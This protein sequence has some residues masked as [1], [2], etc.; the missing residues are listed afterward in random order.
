MSE[1]LKRTL[2]RALASARKSAGMTMTDIVN[3]RIF[4]SRQKLWRLETGQGPF[5][6]AEVQALAD[7]Y[8]VD[9]KTRS[10]WVDWAMRAGESGWWEN[11]SSTVSDFRFGLYVELEQAASRITVCG[12]ELIH[13]L[14]QTEGYHRAVI[15]QTQHTTHEELEESVKLRAER[16]AAVLGGPEPAQL[17]LILSEAAVSFQIGGESTLGK[18]ICH[19]QN[20]NQRPNIS[21]SCLRF[22]DGG[23]PSMRGPYTLLQFS[24]AEAPDIVYIESLDGGRF[25]E[26]PKVVQRFIS[27]AK[28][29]TTKAVPIKEWARERNAVA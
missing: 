12:G 26:D 6:W 10:Q 24:E 9:I 2:G 8:R 23:H 15:E 7:I 5:K 4:G 16:E 27:N 28:L 14:V 11:F 18:Q 22:G 25:I 21:V 29:L 20:L 3:T 19:L 17:K 1:M 13:G